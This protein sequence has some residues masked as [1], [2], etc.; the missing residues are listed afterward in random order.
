M[1]FQRCGSS[2][3]SQREGATEPVRRAAEGEVGVV[4]V[5]GAA[6]V[7]GVAGEVGVAEEGTS[8]RAGGGREVALVVTKA[9][10]YSGLERST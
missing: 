1:Q 7:A 2:Q 9:T 4:G 5:V 3:G 8:R 10:S 6:D